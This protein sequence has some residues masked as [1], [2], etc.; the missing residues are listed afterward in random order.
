MSARARFFAVA[1]CG[2]FPLLSHLGATLG[3]PRLS[4]LGVTLLAGAVLSGHFTGIPAAG[5]T[6]LFLG[7]GFGLA[8]WFP[9]AVVYAPPLFLNLALCAVFAGTLRGGR[10]ALVSG[11]ARV[12]RGGDLPPDLWRY[13][14]LLTGAWAA[15]FA[16]MAGVSLSLALW[17][18]IFSWSLFTN[19][20]NYVLVI[21]FFM[22]EY[23]YRRLRF[24]HYEHATPRELISRIAAYRIFPRSADGR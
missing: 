18:T 6:L 5:L 3:E 8:V 14:R 15:F 1:A 20:V 9:A 2:A 4:A 23:S 11:F 7:V 21:L 22:L 17:G 10:E 16:L 24:P 13:T 12:E 19:L